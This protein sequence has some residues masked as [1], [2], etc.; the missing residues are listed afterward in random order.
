MDWTV[1]RYL[2]LFVV[3]MSFAVVFLL[4]SPFSKPKK[5]AGEKPS[6]APAASYISPEEKV[7]LDASRCSY[8]LDL[9]ALETFRQMAKVAE[10]YGAPAET[11]EPTDILLTTNSSTEPL[12]DA[13]N[14]ACSAPHESA[15]VDVDYIEIQG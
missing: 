9:E 15:Y 14:G 6:D 13:K 8:R 11:G 5:Q 7:L 3:A 2:I 12:R 1:V 4:D 10:R